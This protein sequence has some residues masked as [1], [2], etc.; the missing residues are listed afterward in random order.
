MEE[1]WDNKGGKEGGWTESKETQDSGNGEE[2][3]GREVVLE[4]SS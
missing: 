3:C 4:Y 2:Y 1:R